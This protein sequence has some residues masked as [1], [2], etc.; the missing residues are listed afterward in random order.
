MPTK[1]RPVDRMI[2]PYH[3]LSGPDM[4]HFWAMLEGTGTTVRDYRTGSL[5][6]T[7]VG[8]PSWTSDSEGT[9]LTDFTGTKHAESVSSNL[10]YT[11]A[12]IFSWMAR[13][14]TPSNIAGRYSIYNPSDGE[15]ASSPQWEIGNGNGTA[16]ASHIIIPG[17]FV[18]AADTQLVGSTTYTL[19]YTRGGAGNTHTFYKNGSVATDISTAGA[20]TTSYVN[21]NGKRIIGARDSAGSQPFSGQIWWMAVWDKEL[22]AQEVA[23]ITTDPWVMFTSQTPSTLG[24][25]SVQAKWR[26]K[27]GNG[28][29]VANK[30]G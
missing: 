17:L 22:T 2:V 13:V 25:Q 3:A 18:A 6:M 12:N 4:Y 27:V 24:L 20:E 11:N 14:T 23:D 29:S 15:L 9:G 26:M 30:V 16:G 10:A 8:A 21:P 5:N 19:G 1:P 28:M 7:L